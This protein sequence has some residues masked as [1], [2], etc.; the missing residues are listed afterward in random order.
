MRRE[1]SFLILLVLGIGLGAY[2]YFV[3]R[4]RPPSDEPEAK[5]KVFADL[6]ADQI[7][8]LVVSAGG[9]KTTLAKKDGTWHIVQPITAPADETEVSGITGALTSLERVETVIDNASSV[10]EFG[11][12]PPKAEIAF[13]K[14]GSKEPQRLLIGERAPTGAELYARLPNGPGVF[15]IQSY[16]ESNFVRTTFQLRDKSVLK[17]ERDKVE[18]INLVTPARSITLTH[19]PSE[20]K[21]AEPL[22]VRADFGAAENLVGRLA[23]AQ[24][25]SLVSEQPLDA[26][27]LRKHG[28][29][30]PE[31]TASLTTGSARATLEVGSKTPE[32]DYYARDTSRPLLFTVE[33]ALVE[34]LLKPV[35]DFRRKDLF[36]FRSFNATKVEVTRDGQTYVF[37]K[38][39]APP[40]KDGAA[41]TDKWRQT[42]PQGRD[43]ESSKIDP[44][45]SGFSNVR[46]LSWLAS[47]SGLGLDKP[48]ATVT[49][50]FDDGKK[51]ERVAF[52][53]KGD[54]V[55]V[56][57]AD[58]PGAATI[59]S[60]D[61]ETALR[62]LDDVLK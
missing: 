5:P 41:A 9:D 21:I 55:Y 16:V 15:T 38:V 52:A 51:T 61:Y 8:E 34:E 40:D 4:K 6:Q 20:W 30:T 29:D 18:S 35:S 7:E 58:E 53:R 48:Q 42:A 14:Q 26:A 46:A 45:L 43:I 57:R 27:A 32:G 17:F 13:R 11:L 10:K 49:A 2:I 62:A 22:A 56:T 23:S 59:S 50:T 39:K 3:E 37:E 1:R 47:T 54:T 12:D 24:M 28:L 33:S 44:L 36:E 60:A 19:T 31:A 25:K